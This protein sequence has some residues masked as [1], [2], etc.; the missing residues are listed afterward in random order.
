MR[1]IQH[2]EGFIATLLSQIRLSLM[3]QNIGTQSEALEIAMKLE[4]SPVGENAV[5][6]NQIQTQ[7]GNMTL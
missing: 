1:D 3:Q 5:S 2:K 4:T 7:L 6:M